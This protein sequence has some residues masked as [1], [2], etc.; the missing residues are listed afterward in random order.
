MLCIRAP[1]VLAAQQFSILCSMIPASAP[2][3]TVSTSVAPPTAAPYP[4]ATQAKVA[5]YPPTT[6][7]PNVPPAKLIPN[8]SPL[9][10][11]HCGGSVV[12][13]SWERE[14]CLARED[15]KH[16]ALCLN[17]RKRIPKELRGSS[18]RH[19]A[20]YLAQQLD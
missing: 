14:R 1:S 4:Q 18:K 19:R 7:Q 15:F 12:L 17:C 20:N 5:P 9:P 3:T 8:V 6:T 11:F 2:P 16:N 13:A 10:C